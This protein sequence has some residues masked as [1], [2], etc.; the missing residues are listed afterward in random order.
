MGGVDLKGQMVQTIPIGKKTSKQWYVK[1]FKRLLNVAVHNTFMVYNS[2]SK[3][4]H[5]TYRLDVV[6]AFILTHKP[7]VTSPAG[8]GRS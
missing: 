8:P 6:K 7:H 1:I 5:V 2:S 3:T 4:H